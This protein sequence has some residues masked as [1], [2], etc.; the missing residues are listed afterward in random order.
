[1]KLNAAFIKAYKGCVLVNVITSDASHTRRTRRSIL[2][3]EDKKEVKADETS[4]VS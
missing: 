2:E 1:M 3:T 4:D